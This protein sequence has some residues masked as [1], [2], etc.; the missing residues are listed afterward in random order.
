M[1]HEQF[2]PMQQL[3]I[4]FHKKLVKGQLWTEVTH[5][6]IWGHMKV[7]P[8]M[9]QVIWDHFCLGVIFHSVA[10]LHSKWW[11][12]MIFGHIQRCV[13]NQLTYFHQY[14]TME[15]WMVKWGH[16]WHWYPWWPMWLGTLCEQFCHMQPLCI[17]FTKSWLKL[18]CGQRS[19]MWQSG[20]I[21]RSY[22]VCTKSY[23][24]IFVWVSYFILLLFCIGSGEGSWYLATFG[25]V[26][27]A[28]WPTSINIQQWNC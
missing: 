3:Y 16:K 2:C 27:R 7:L 6:T 13:Q 20:V 15:L 5:V 18:N 11:G 26:S 23:E 12:V 8:S 25:N 28:I 19:H 10:F 1:L 17:K 24:T 14:W 4:K 9:C 21:W 22:L